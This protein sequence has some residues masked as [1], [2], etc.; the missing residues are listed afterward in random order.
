MKSEKEI[1]ETLEQ[2]GY[3]FIK[4][5]SVRGGNRIFEM[6]CPEGHITEKSVGNFNQ[7][8]MCKICSYAHLSNLKTPDV[9]YYQGLLLSNNRYHKDMYITSLL[10]H[11]KLNFY[12]AVC[13]EDELGLS[14]L[15]DGNFKMARSSVKV[16]CIPCRCNKSHVLTEVQNTYLLSKR[17]REVGKDFVCWEGKY[18]NDRTKF[19]LV[20][21]K[22]TPHKMT[23]S[24]FKANSYRCKCCGERK[25][26]F[27]YNSKA[28]LYLYEVIVDGKLGCKVGISN[29]IDKRL[30]N[31]KGI[32]KL[33]TYRLLYEWEFSTGSL[34]FDIEQEV[35]NKFDNKFFSKKEMPDGY[36]ESYNI[37]DL[38]EILNH[39]SL[40][41]HL[42]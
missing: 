4:W 32:N 11:R 23:Y 6:E 42:N 14:G 38:P 30:Y 15:C 31:Q 17:L 28:T 13:S 2:E 25:E 7:G 34:A 37:K 40:P 26:G 39:I 18:K 19:K 24:C 9:S 1:T 29:C 36:T 41:F 22:G 35:K 12:C 8:K 27:D 20:C 10:P 21:E 33:C 3:K 16:G 5:L